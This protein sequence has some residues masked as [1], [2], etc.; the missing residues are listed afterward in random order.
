[1]H[2][3]RSYGNMILPEYALAFVKTQAFINAGKQ[4]FT[5][6]V[7]QQRVGKE[8]ISE[9]LF[10]VPPYQEQ[11]RIV[12]AIRRAFSTIGEIETAIA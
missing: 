11:V 3:L 12:E 7:G 2:V 9:T 4:E 1:M 10:P 8:Y 6:A 5:G